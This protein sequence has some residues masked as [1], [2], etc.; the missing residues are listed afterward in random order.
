MI[1][2]SLLRTS[3]PEAFGYPSSNSVGTLVNVAENALTDTA[4]LPARRDVLEL[5]FQ[6]IDSPGSTGA[7]VQFNGGGQVQVESSFFNVGDSYAMFVHG[8]SAGAAAV[9]QSSPG[10]F[11]TFVALQRSS[12]PHRQHDDGVH[13]EGLTGC[14]NT[15]GEP[16]LHRVSRSSLRP[17]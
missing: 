10:N 15:E 6:F 16:A 3:Q 8:S 4:P 9:N 5:T 13:R 7:S 2:F 17:S 12:R 11:L 14:G 1:R